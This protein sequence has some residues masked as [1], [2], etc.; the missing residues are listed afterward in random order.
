M[1]NILQLSLSENNFVNNRKT[2]TADYS[3]YPEPMSNELKYK[4]SKIFDVHPNNLAV[5][6]GADEAIFVISALFGGRGK[7][8]AIPGISY[9][10][11]RLSSEATGSNI[12]YYEINTSGLN[13]EELI[14][15][16]NRASVCYLPN[17][18]NPLGNALSRDDLAEVIKLV[19]QTGCVLVIDEAYIDFA[20]NAV[21]YESIIDLTKRCRNLIVLRSFSKGLGLAGLRC[22]FIASSENLSEQI[23]RAFLAVPFNVGIV[24]QQIVSETLIEYNSLIERIKIENRKS[25]RK[26]TDELEALG[27][28]PLKSQANF[29]TVAIGKSVPRIVEHLRSNEGIEVKNTSPMGLEGYVRV[30][31]PLVD[32]ASLVASKLNDAVKYFNQNHESGGK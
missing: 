9:G 23:N 25:V 17:P 3:R 14:D 28:E 32:D 6:N 16:C 24:A 7:I 11:Y 31:A 30:G 8:A 4:I 19:S 2:I 18:H 20:D 1:Q 5:T 12:E 13:R 29:V 21:G 26:L 10:G 22:G 15:V 27:F